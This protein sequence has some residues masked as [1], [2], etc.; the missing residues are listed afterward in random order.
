MLN[1]LNLKSF[2]AFLS[3]SRTLNKRALRG[4]SFVRTA[5]IVSVLDRKKT[6]RN[7]F[8]LT[9]SVVMRVVTCTFPIP[10]TTEWLCGGPASDVNPSALRRRAAIM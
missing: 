4:G 7:K 6:C 1:Y 8:R 9:A 10:E 2:E 5:S 3:I